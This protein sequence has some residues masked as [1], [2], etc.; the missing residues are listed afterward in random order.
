MMR[1]PNQDRT[2]PGLVTALS[3]GLALLS[4]FDIDTPRLGIAELARRT[5][6]QAATVRR[7]AYTL[8][9]IGYLDHQGDTDTY[10]LGA[11]TLALG[12]AIVDS[13]QLRDFAAPFMQELADETG[14][15]V[16]LGSRQHLSMVCVEVR[17]S[18]SPVAL[19]MDVGMHLPLATS[20][21]GRAYLAICPDA[22]RNAL[23]E[24]I[25][26]SDKGAWPE[27]GQAIE[28]SLGIYEVLDACGSFGDWHCDV[29]G[30]AVGFRP[31]YGLPSMSVTCGAPAAMAS[32]E[33]MI[34]QVR[35]R[36]L[37]VVQRMEQ[38]FGWPPANR[39][40]AT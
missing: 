3:R 27:V 9:K 16:A 38:E 39:Q 7:M 36:L 40:P 8:T 5:Q 2:Q 32:P 31:G 18:S 24:K 19:K 11:A 34:N 23:I 12:N 37:N 22:E 28:R 26:E 17:M 14:T 13:F 33:Y 29:N 15:S 21:L 25:R 6:L 35:P 10:S 1:E 20:A 4:S 30:I